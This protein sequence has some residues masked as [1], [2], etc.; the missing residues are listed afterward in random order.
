LILA[1]IQ[2]LYR[3]ESDGEE[4]TPE[5]RRGLRQERS[6]PLLERIEELRAGLEAKVLPKSPLGEALRY[7]GNQWD[8]LKRYLEDGRL[9][10]DN[11]GAENQLR[12]VAVGRKNWP[13]AGSLD[14]AKWAAILF[15]LVQSCRLAGVD[16]FVYFRDVLMRLPTHPQRLIGQLAPRRWA[17][18]F[19]KE[20]AA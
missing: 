19:A 13:F 11:N 2:E 7:M 14:G 12:I 16:L 10:I 4:L 15:S 18:I 8:A 20:I 1:L 9:S 3:V 6:V 5:E 17:E